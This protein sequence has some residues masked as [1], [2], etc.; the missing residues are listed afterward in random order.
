MIPQ[1]AQDPAKIESRLN[2]TYQVARVKFHCEQ[3]NPYEQQRGQKPVLRLLIKTFSMYYPYGHYTT[4]GFCGLETALRTSGL[5]TEH[6]LPGDG[7]TRSPNS[8]QNLRFLRLGNPSSFLQKNQYQPLA[9]HLSVPKRVSNMR[10]N[11]MADSTNQH[12]N[13]VLAT[14]PQ[15]NSSKPS[16]CP[17]SGRNCQELLRPSQT[18]SGQPMLCLQIACAEGGLQTAKPSRGVYY[19]FDI[20]EYKVYNVSHIEM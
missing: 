19:N 8:P 2:P 13:V 3:L 16:P 7:L 6:R 15:C 14:L 4:G 1:E 10:N 5:Q 18:I 12:M 11:T 9:P 20:I 17:R